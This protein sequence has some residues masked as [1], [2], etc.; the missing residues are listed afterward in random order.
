MTKIPRWLQDVDSLDWDE[1]VEKTF[2]M[3]KDLV[4]T[5]RER[6]RLKR[7]NK[8][9]GGGEQLKLMEADDVFYPASRKIGE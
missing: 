6:N 3:Y 5:R 2:D 7:E 8:R 4:R 1:L 9:L